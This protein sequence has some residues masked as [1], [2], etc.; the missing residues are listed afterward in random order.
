MALH[1]GGAQDSSR[2]VILNPD[3]LLMDPDQVSSAVHS[4]TPDESPSS[5]VLESPQ[6]QL[7]TD[8]I[9]SSERTPSPSSRKLLPEK[10]PLSGPG[11]LK[12]R[13]GR[14]RRRNEAESTR[15]EEMESLENE[16]R[17]NNFVRLFN[18]DHGRKNSMTEITDLDVILTAIEEEALE[19]RNDMESAVD[20]QAVKEFFIQI[21]KSF[22]ETIDVYREN[23][24]LKADLRKAKSKVNKLR[25]DLLS[26]QQKRSR[27][28][29]K[30]E[31]E[32]NKRQ[33]NSERK[34]VLEDFSSFLVKLE[35][36]QKECRKDLSSKKASKLD[37]ASVSNLPSLLIEGQSLLTAANQLKSVNDTLQQRQ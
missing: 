23:Q 18:A 8:N 9:V 33:Q 34:K 7:Q 6:A 14:K 5:I 16:Y 19:I 13:A 21:R 24:M 31:R 27:T 26:V 28:S 20:K 10:T 30:L 4:R 36:L 11:A 12:T 25:K 15:N 32:K 29:A 17:E 2:H 22:S 35:E 1:L 37:Y 3:G